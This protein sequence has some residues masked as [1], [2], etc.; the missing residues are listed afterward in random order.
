M[1]KRSIL[2]SIFKML[3]VLSGWL[4]Y[5]L[6]TSLTDFSNPYNLLIGFICLGLG[7]YGAEKL[8][9]AMYDKNKESS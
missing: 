3:G 7:I 9:K 5:Y 6:I 2:S 4:L 1:K 8:Y